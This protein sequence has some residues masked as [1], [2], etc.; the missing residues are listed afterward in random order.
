[1]TKFADRIASYDITKL[2]V[3][4]DTLD[5]ILF[6]EI[7]D[8]DRH[9]D[10]VSGILLARRLGIPTELNMVVFQKNAADFWKILEFCEAQGLPLKLLDLVLY[11]SLVR[12]EL[13]PENYW[14]KEYFDLSTL[15]P[16]LT[17]RYGEP[18][19]I[20]LSNERGIPMLQFSAK[21][22]CILTLKCGRQGSTYANVCRSCDIF[23]CQEGLFHLSISAEGNLTP[24]RLRRDLTRSLAGLSDTQIRGIFEETMRYYNDSFN[25]A[26]TVKFSEV[27]SSPLRGYRQ[28]YND[29][30]N[31]IN[32]LKK[33]SCLD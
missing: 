7:T 33:G 29:N 25:I 19:T 4:L 32:K 18:Q 30:I 15:V 13:T 22:G 31:Y 1:M 26:D 16:E 8:S 11:D 5:P 24:C 20:H 28:N 23:P 3:S 9:Q 21:G 10:V 6:K 14:R 2:K 12:N 27:R 17:K